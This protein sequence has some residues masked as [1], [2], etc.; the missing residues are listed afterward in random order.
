MKRKRT[1][2]NK[3]TKKKGKKCPRGGVQI[4]KK[5]ARIAF[6]DENRKHRQLEQ[7]KADPKKCAGA[8]SCSEIRKS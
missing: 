1:S 7:E 3:N 5:A 6:A 2:I 8:E 4:F